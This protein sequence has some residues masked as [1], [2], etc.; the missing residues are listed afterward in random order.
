MA[1]KY[2]SGIYKQHEGYKSFQPSLVNTEF[3]WT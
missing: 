2:K 1:D 3:E